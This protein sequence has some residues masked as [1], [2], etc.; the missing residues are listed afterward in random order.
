MRKVLLIISFFLF[1][2][3]SCKKKNKVTS[4]DGAKLFTFTSLKADKDTVRQGEVTNIHAQIS[5]QGSYAW[6]ASAGDIFGSGATVL[7]G[8]STCCIGNHTITCTVKDD[9]NNSETKSVV[10]FVK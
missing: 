6:V 3:L 4:D 2:F 7:F 5:G 9:H 1:S 8:A 10:V